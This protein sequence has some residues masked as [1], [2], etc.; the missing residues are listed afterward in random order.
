M[1]KKRVIIL[2]LALVLIAGA[3]GGF[4]A[5]RDQQKRDMLAAVTEYSAVLEPGELDS[6]EQYPNLRLADLSGSSCY[7]EMDAWANAHPGV[8]LRY[9]LPLGGS[10]CLN[11]AGQL[12]LREGAYEPEALLAALPHL[13]ALESLTLPETERSPE[14]LEALAQAAPQAQLRWS[15]SILGGEYW[16]DTE[17]LDLGGV[18]AGTLEQELSQLQ[19]LP[20]LKRVELVAADGA[21]PYSMEQ[22]LAVRQALPEAEVHYVF[23]LFGQTVDSGEESLIY[24]NVPIGREGLDQIRL[25][26]ALMPNCTY[27]KLADCGIDNDTMTALRD[28]YAGRV[29]VVWQVYLDRYGFPTDVEVIH[30]A[31]ESPRKPIRDDNSHI[32]NYCTDLVYLDLG[33]NTLTN[34]EFCRYMP[35]LKNLILSYNS[36]ADLSP[37]SACP[38]LEFVELKCTQ[39]SDLTPLTA[40]TKLRLLNVTATNVHDVTPVQEIK[41]LERFY[42]VWN[43]V[44]Q[45][46]KAELAVALPDCWITYQ[47]DDGFNVGW[48]YDERGVRAAWYLE[49]YRI[50]RYRVLDWYFGPIED[51]A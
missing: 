20:A 11:S 21:S 29:K 5:W 7:D 22:A 17:S 42:C 24:E 38:E 8:E 35:K 4:L 23:T 47:M 45:E 34:I 31:F 40:C 18:P 2:C 36:V 50:Y 9:T 30:L 43:T 6:L 10:E 28:E 3:V 48:S 33:H 27:L 41:N 46:Q 26:L 15:R 25:A 32:L 13:R 49:I 44:P 37:L 14:Q 39:V 1:K 19:L 51:P 12:E 16:D